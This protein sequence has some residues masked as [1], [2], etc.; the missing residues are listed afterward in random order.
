MAGRRRTRARRATASSSSRAY[1]YRKSYAEAQVERMTWAL[2]VGVFAVL[3]LLP[4][5][6]TVH[7]WI[8]P[9]AGAVILLGS[10]FY[11]Y[12]RGW[13]VAPVTLPEGAVITLVTRGDQVVLPQG[14]TR[15]QGWDQVTVLAHAPDEDKI[16]D[17]FTRAFPAEVP[18]AR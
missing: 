8:P 12:S 15:L 11:Q 13:R 1:T 17:T 3:Y 7:N 10:G 6:A 14:A 18:N 9:L 5:G 2:L 4:E 16:R